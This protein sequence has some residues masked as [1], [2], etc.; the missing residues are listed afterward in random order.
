MQPKK[1]VSDKR[2]IRRVPV[3]VPV[4]LHSRSTFGKKGDGVSVDVTSYGVLLETTVPLAV[5]EDVEIAFGLTNSI[6]RSMTAHVA[7][8]SMDDRNKKTLIGCYFV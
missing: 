1:N 6:R 7:W 4:A 2:R 8:T 5:G 3:R